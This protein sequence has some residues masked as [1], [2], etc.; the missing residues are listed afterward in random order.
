MADKTPANM[1]RINDFFH[2][3]TFLRGEIDEHYRS[4]EVACQV[5]LP[6]SMDPCEAK[7]YLKLRW[8][9]KSNW[10]QSAC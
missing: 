5:P 1:H 9:A 10:G 2:F 3:M 4:N 7:S 6:V 8:G